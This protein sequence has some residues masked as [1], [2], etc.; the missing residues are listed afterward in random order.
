MKHVAS[1]SSRDFKQPLSRPKV[2]IYRLLV[3]VVDV[4]DV[5]GVVVVVVVVVV[6]VVPKNV[7][8]HAEFRPQNIRE[9]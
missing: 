5:D 4:V 3:D 1:F 7:P 2:N 8:S 6:M 9:A